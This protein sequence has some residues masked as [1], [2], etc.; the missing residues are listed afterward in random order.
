VAWFSIGVVWGLAML[1]RLVLPTERRAD[2]ASLR[3]VN[4]W[5]TLDSGF[6]ALFFLGYLFFFHVSQLRDTY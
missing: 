4:Q 6:I 3:Y 5:E 2:A 1:H